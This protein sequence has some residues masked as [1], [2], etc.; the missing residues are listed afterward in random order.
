M[1]T[2]KFA[3]WIQKFEEVPSK[4]ILGIRHPLRRFLSYTS[5]IW[6]I[7]VSDTDIPSAYLST[8]WIV[9]HGKGVVALGD[10]FQVRQTKATKKNDG[11][12]KQRNACSLLRAS[13][14]LYEFW[15]K[16]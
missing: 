3:E 15:A 6:T 2:V 5:T 16:S 9:L 8:L 7:R 14:P 13:P 1:E 11:N 10:I 12:T 4:N